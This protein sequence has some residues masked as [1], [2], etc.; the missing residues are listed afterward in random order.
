MK[1][2]VSRNHLRRHRKRSGLSQ[3]EISVL[4]GYRN[5]WQVLRHER[6]ET[7]PP[8]LMAL[9]YEVIFRVPVSAIFVGIHSTALRTVEQNLAVFERNLTGRSARAIA[10]KLKWLKERHK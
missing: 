2:Q 7:L 1:H 4:L 5:Q 3:R 6:S 8:L 9:A 10:Q